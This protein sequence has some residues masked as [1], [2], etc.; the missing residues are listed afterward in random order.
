MNLRKTRV[1]CVLDRSGSMEET[2]ENTINAF[3]KFTDELKKGEGECYL[4]L[5]MFDHDYFYIF[6]KPI[7]GVS[8]LTAEKYTTRGNT[9]LLD[10]QGR[11]IEELGRELRDTPE[12]DRPGNVILVTQTDGYEN[13]SRNY[14]MG[15]I[16]EMVEHQQKIYNW[17]FIYLG[18]NQDAIKAA[19]GMGISVQYAMNN[20]V[21]DPSAMA[22]SYA[23][24]AQNINTLR[25]AGSR[26]IISPL[27]SYTHE[28]RTRSM[29]GTTMESTLAVGTN[30]EPTKP[31]AEA[32]PAKK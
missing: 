29:G 15:K 22:Y 3:N 27:Q 25:S 9:A 12:N 23:A 1:V 10:A 21:N 20:N 2:K 16:A 19:A 31:K 5:V 30:L 28:D 24:T 8:H 4:K 11:T 7:H 13:A 17:K 26:G 6:D 18:A 32:E 14:T